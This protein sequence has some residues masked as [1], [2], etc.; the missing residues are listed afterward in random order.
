MDKKTIFEIAITGSSG[1]PYTLSFLP[2]GE[3][4]VVFCNCGAGIFG[5]FCKHKRAVVTGD[6]SILAE[7]KAPLEKMA[8]ARKLLQE[9]GMFDALAGHEQELA[10]L[11]AEEDKLKKR[12]KASKT[13]YIKALNAGGK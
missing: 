12:V 4:L 5:K 10:A 13:A 11:E 3:S 1:T 8:K 9:Y 6:I 7:S 2:K